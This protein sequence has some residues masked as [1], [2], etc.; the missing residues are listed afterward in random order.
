MTDPKLRLVRPEEGVIS[1]KSRARPTPS[2]GVFI[3]WRLAA[4]KDDESVRWE[5][6]DGRFVTISLG[7]D[8]EAGRAVVADSNGQRRVVETYE[9]ALDLARS[10]RT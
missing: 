6:V 8:D 5:S 10:W 1:E 3:R 7:R 4:A 9:E 2:A